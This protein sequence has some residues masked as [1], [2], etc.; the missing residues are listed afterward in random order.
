MSP[1]FYPLRE[2]EI[3]ERATH[4]SPIFCGEIETSRLKFSSEIKNFDRDW[5][6]RSRS[7]VFDRWALWVQESPGKIAGKIFP[8]RGM[9]QILGFRAP[10]RANLPGTLGPHCQ[11]LVP[12]FRAGRFFGRLIFYHYWCWGARGAVPVKTS[13]GNNFPRKYQRI[14]RNYYQYWC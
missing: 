10:G 7:N 6:F 11:D 8:N 4:R 9:L 5:K 13:T 3:F 14:P 12:T 2:N 1:L